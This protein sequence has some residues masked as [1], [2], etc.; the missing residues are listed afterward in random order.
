MAA[1]LSASNSGEGRAT[2]LQLLSMY[3]DS[4]TVNRASL[5]AKE[6]QMTT[7]TGLI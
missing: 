6:S 7:V 5:D 1:E 4:L 2:V 3:S